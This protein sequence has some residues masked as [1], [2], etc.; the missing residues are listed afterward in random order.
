MKK[1]LRKTA[2]KSPR[3]AAPRRLSVKKAAP[4]MT[5][6]EVIHL[7][8]ISKR[9]EESEKAWLRMTA[10]PEGDETW[11]QVEEHLL[12]HASADQDR[13]WKFFSK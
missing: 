4:E 7:E 11:T 5:P 6:D 9:Y 12:T 10:A 3:K 8:T 2:A 1:T 13:R